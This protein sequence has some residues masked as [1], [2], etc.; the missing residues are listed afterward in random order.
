MEEDNVLNRFLNQKGFTL[1][2]LMIVVAIIGILAAIAIP[3][4]LGV[5]KKAKLRS[6]TEGAANIRSELAN[7]MMV[8]QDGESFIVDFDG[9]GDVDAADDAARPANIAAIGAQWDVAYGAAPGASVKSPYNGSNFLY[10]T[11]AVA[12]S[13]QI[14]VVCAGTNCTISGYSDN[15]G[16]GAIFDAE[17]SVW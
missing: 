13:G 2:E 4:Y 17:V 15:A 14:A 3:S 1:V 16:D 10:N 9:D 8:V 7:W 5:Q 6:V 12:G 11:N